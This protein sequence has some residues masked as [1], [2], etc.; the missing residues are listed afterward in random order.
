[1][2]L[3]EDDFVT[4]AFTLSFIYAV[5]GKE[6]LMRNVLNDFNGIHGINLSFNELISLNLNVIAAYLCELTKRFIQL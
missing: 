5:E 1:M 4:K 2:E 6:S 3:N